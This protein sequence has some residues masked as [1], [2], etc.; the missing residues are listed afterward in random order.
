MNS[1]GLTP[2]RVGLSNCGSLAVSLLKRH[3]RFWEF[4]PPQ[5][6][7]IGPRQELGCTT[8]SEDPSIMKPE[9]WQQARE[10]LADALEL[11]PEDRSTFLDRAC[12]SE[13]ALRREVERLLAANDEARSDFL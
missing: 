1:P 4:R 2:N 6:R 7:D 8:R 10:V 5:S 12:S 9:Q 3:P 11:K 13:H